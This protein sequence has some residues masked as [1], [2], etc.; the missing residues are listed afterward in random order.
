M[1]SAGVPIEPLGR[2]ALP[3]P[4]PRSMTCSAGR[5]VSS[6]CST[7]ITRV[8]LVRAAGA[9]CRA[10]CGCRADAGRW[11]ARRGC[12]TRRA[13]WSRAGR[14]AECAA[15]RRRTASARRSSV[16]YGKPTSDQESQALLNLTKNLSA[17]LIAHGVAILGVSKIKPA[18]LSLCVVDRGSVTCQIVLPSTL[19]A[20]ARWSSRRPWQAV[21]GISVISSSSSLS[22]FH[23]SLAQAISNKARDRRKQRRPV[24][25]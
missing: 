6:S 10:A 8:A 11:S 19:T 25:P 15:P 9:A 24:P 4:G 13:G 20:W 23:R 5:M 12:S 2:R 17:A 16:R 7:T 3:A 14:R 1:I 22:S 21:H 18:K